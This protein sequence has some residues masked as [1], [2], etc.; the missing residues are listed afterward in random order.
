MVV[1]M[2][3]DICARLYDAIVALPLDWHDDD[4]NKGA[5]KVVMT[6]SASDEPHL[7]PH[8]TTK[9]QQSVFRFKPHPQTPQAPGGAQQT[10]QQRQL[11]ARLADHCGKADRLGRCNQQGSLAI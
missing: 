5:I 2:S 11:C 7:Q 8:H 10:I 4:P 1:A 9:Q 3:R 6:A